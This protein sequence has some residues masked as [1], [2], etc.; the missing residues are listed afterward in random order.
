MECSSDKV[1]AKVTKKTLRWASEESFTIAAGES[2]E[3]VSP[4]LAENE[5]RVMEVCLSITDNHIYT[6]RMKDS[7]GDSWSDGA[8]IAIE[9][10][11]DHTVFKNMM[12]EKSNEE[13]LFALY[14]PIPKNG[15][16]KMGE[17]IQ[18][19]WNQ[20]SFDD[21]AWSSFTCGS[22]TQQ[23]SG[24]LYF[25][26]TFIGITDMAAV[27]IQFRYAHGIL[28]FI[29]G[30]E[31]FRDNL[32]SGAISPTT[33]ASGS[34]ATS[35]YHGVIR[36]ASVA[37]SGESVLAVE[38]HF[39]DSSSRPID[40]NAFL[41][42]GAGITSDNKCFVSYANLTATSP[43]YA[44]IAKVFDYT[45]NSGATALKAELPHTFVVSFGNVVPLVNGLRIYAHL[46]PGYCPSS[47]L[48]EGAESSTA[49]SWS[50]IIDVTNQDHTYMKWTQL[51]VMTD[52]VYYKALRTTIRQSQGISTYLYEI[53]YLV[54]NNAITTVSYPEERYSFY[55]RYDPVHLEIVEFGVTH[56]Q[57]LPP[58]PEGLV[59]DT[60]SCAITG[61]ATTGS[62][63][64]TYSIVAMA[65]SHSLT[66]TVRLAFLLCEGTLLRVV[67]SYQSFP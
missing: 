51:A 65:G 34:Y 1:Y 14:S 44:S 5:E 47:F 2:V 62:P 52:P 37:E 32:P 59:F 46:N 21:S 60:A 35:D 48:V 36:P 67:R 17:S 16:W 57:I 61:S 12:T 53:Q 4:S 28:A 43:H 40:F 18:A 42:Y 50:P 26:K 39:V 64:T 66:G 31:V 33:P 15:E 6:L 19:G 7:R 30:V 49:A 9:D 3:F 55:A 24:T 45:R 38:L 11:N 10:S 27:D 41:S 54:C 13:T 63:E 29:N 20:Y 8:W 23:S 22:T 58:L 56:C 25:R